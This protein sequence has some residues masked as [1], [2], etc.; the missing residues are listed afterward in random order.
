MSTGGVGEGTAGCW[1]GQG[2]GGTGHA[3]LQEGAGCGGWGGAA[4]GRGGHVGRCN[5]GR[6]GRLGGVGLPGGSS[7]CRRPLPG[8]W[9]GAEP[10]PQGG[11]RRG[12]GLLLLLQDG[13]LGTLAAA[14]DTPPVAVVGQLPAHLWGQPTGPVG[15]KGRRV[16]APLV[17]APW[18]EGSGGD[19][20]WVPG[21]WGALAETRLSL[22]ME[23]G[24]G[25]SVE[26]PEKS[27]QMRKGS[28]GG[29]VSVLSY[30]G[31][32]EK[33]CRGLGLARRG[34]GVGPMPWSPWGC[35]PGVGGQRTTHQEAAWLVQS[36]L[37]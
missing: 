28:W 19:W 37:E 14:A 22:H 8:S 13:G 5:G 26:A 31:A 32:V 25:P 7:G 33:R 2:A 30:G 27:E 18:K 24:A 29:A 4:A 21:P 1:G 23:A 6:G 17:T 11:G 10:L 20:A 15:L 35:D 9:D 3:G 16:M 12:L 36:R 34:A